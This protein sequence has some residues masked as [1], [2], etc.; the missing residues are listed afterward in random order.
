MGQLDKY[1]CYWQHTQCLVKDIGKRSGT[2]SGSYRHR[3]NTGKHHVNPSET[4]RQPAVKPASRALADSF[5]GGSREQ[6]FMQWQVNMV[7]FSHLWRQHEHSDIDV[8]VVS[9]HLSHHSILFPAHKAI[10][11]ASPY[12]RA[13]VRCLLATVDVA[14]GSR[15]ARGACVAQSPPLSPFRSCCACADEAMDASGRRQLQRPRQ[16]LLAGQQWQPFL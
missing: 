3:Q 13:Q 2:G 10:L 1:T 8:C 14:S 6:C 12:F 7:S 9:S 4:H 5:T 15:V 11:T 16:P